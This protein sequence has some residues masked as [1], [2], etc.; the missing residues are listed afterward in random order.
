MNTKLHLKPQFV[1]VVMNDPYRIHVK[2]SDCQYLES[3]FHFHDN[4][5]YELVWIK[6]SF[7]KR[8]IGDH[9]DEFTTDDLVLMA[10]KLP[11]KWINDNLFYEP[12]STLRAKTI[13]IHFNGNLLLSTF[14]S[15]ESRNDIEQLLKNAK[16]GIRLTGQDS[17]KVRTII[18]RL[19]HSQGL[20]RGI[21]LLQIMDIFSRSEEYELLASPAYKVSLRAKE[22]KRMNDVYDHIFKHFQMEITLDEVAAIAHMTPNAFC[23]FFKTH[24]NYSFV[25]FLNSI[26]INHACKLLGNPD[27]SVTGVCF[28]SG[29][30]NTANFNKC[31]K[32]KIGKTPIQ[33]RVNLQELAK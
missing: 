14:G 5:I 21:K 12:G 2:K 19:D 18:R 30:N 32:K 29:F 3:I 26:R 31:F 17:R 11:H 9:V 16:R 1:D 33:Y 20:K 13:V 27:V 24:S 7:G 4:N 6:E 10:P 25:D 15:S 23:R 22:S 28:Q 8:I